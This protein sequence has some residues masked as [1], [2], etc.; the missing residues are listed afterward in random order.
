MRCSPRQQVMAHQSLIS[1]LLL[2]LF[3]LCGFHSI[4]ALE[5]CV[6]KL[7]DHRYASYA[8]RYLEYCVLQCLGSSARYRSRSPSGRLGFFHILSFAEV[9]SPD[10]TATG[11]IQ[12]GSRAPP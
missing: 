3:S 10:P 6:N 9:R 5:T 2:L 12:V 8:Y 1:S 7:L 11:E 4:H